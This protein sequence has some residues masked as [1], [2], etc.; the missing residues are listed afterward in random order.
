MKDDIQLFDN[1][2][3]LLINTKTIISIH[4]IEMSKFIFICITVMIFTSANVLGQSKTDAVCAN[5]SSQLEMYRCLSKQYTNTDKELNAIYSKILNKLKKDN[6]LRPINILKE[7]ERNWVVYRNNFGKVY[8]E[9]YKG[10]S[11]MPITVLECEIQTTRARITE[12]NSLFEDVKILPL[13]QASYCM[14]KQ[15]IYAKVYQV[16]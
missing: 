5:A 3:C 16:Y 13:S 4:T 12:L 10:G 14:K 1:G 2:I 15:V 8:Q 9:L 6:S 7:S 11:I